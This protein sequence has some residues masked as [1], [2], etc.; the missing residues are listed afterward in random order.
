MNKESVV[1]VPVELR[2]RGVAVRGLVLPTIAT[3]L[4]ALEVEQER[5]ALETY[6]TGVGEGSAIL[7]LN[8]TRLIQ[9]QAF[10]RL[11][12]GRGPVVPGSSPGAMFCSWRVA[13]GGVIL[14]HAGHRFLVIFPGPVAVAGKSTSLGRGTVRVVQV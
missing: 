11:A 5:V 7:A 13:T 6:R 8:I 4:S 10:A 12:K 2:Q 3:R 14:N 1:M 9:R